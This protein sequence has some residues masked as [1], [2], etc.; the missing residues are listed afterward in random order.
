YRQS[1][2]QFYWENRVRD[3]LKYWGFSELYT[4]PMVSEDLLEETPE[5]SVT[6]KNPLTEDHIYMRRTLVPSLLEAA[7]ENKNRS[8]LKLFELAN[9]YIKKPKSLPDEKL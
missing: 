6:I 8:E 4:Y 9:V 2:D 3:A 1:Y 7:R 5:N